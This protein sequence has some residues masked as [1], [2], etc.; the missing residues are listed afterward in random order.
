M[1]GDWNFSTSEARVQ[2]KLPSP[3]LVFRM[4]G[5]LQEIIEQMVVQVQLAEMDCRN[6]KS[7][8]IKGNPLR[9]EALMQWRPLLQLPKSSF[10]LSSRIGLLVAQA[11]QGLKQEHAT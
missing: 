5:K 11:P 10:S 1:L 8:P 6:P 2:N 4:K 7:S 3:F 9:I